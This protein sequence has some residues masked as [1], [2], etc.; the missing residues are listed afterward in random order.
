MS[1]SRVAFVPR[2]E[3]KVKWSECCSFV[4]RRGNGA[5]AISIGKNCDKFGIVVHE[6][7]HVV[8][9]WHEHTRPDRDKHVQII[10][11]NIVAGQEY[12]FN[13]LTEEEVNSLGLNYDYESIMHYARNT[14]SRSTALDTILPIRGK[15]V[16]IGQRVRLSSG[17]IA[18]TNMLYKCPA[19]GRTFQEPSSHFQSPGYETT[20]LSHQRCEWRISATQ[21]ER[22]SFEV[23]ALDIDPSCDTGYLEIRDGY[24]NKSPLLGRFCGNRVSKEKFVSSGHRMLVIYQ[25][26][27]TPIF[28]K[29]FQAKYEALCGG[30]LEQSEGTIQSPNYPDEYRANKECIWKI[31]VAPGSQVALTFQAFEVEYHDNCGYDFVEVRDGLDLH[32][33]FLA[34]LCGYK[35]PE[36][37]RSTS[38]HMLVRFFS[39][40]SV[41]KMG[42]SANFVTACGRTFQ[43]PS[44]HFQSPGYETTKLSHQRC[45]WRISATQGERISFEVTALDIDPSCDTGY[46]EIRDG[47]WNK[48]PLLGRFCG[49]RVSKEKFVSS[50]H[51]MLVIYQTIPTPIFYKG[52]QAK[53][54][55]ACGGV[56]K[57]ERGVITSPSFPDLYPSN[58]QCIWEIVAPP[59][60]RITLN[61]T[62]F[63]LEGTNQ[64][65]EYDS[66]DL[67]TRLSPDED[68]KKQGTYCGSRL[69]PVLTSEGSALRI[70]FVSDNSVQ[71][72]GFAALFFT[73]QDE[74]ASNNG[75]CQQICKNTVGS[76]QCS[77]H[78]GFVLHPNGHDCKEGS[79]VH[80]VSSTDGVV[81]SPNFPDNYPSRKECTWK[82]ETTP[83]HR[84]KLVFDSFEL[85]PHQECAYDHVA[86]YD[87]ESADS[88]LLGRFCGSKVPHPIISTAQ[89]MLMAFRS[90]PSV[91]RNGFRA[92]HST[93]CGGRLSATQKPSLL[94][95]HAKYGDQNYGS[96]ADC[97]WIVTAPNSGKVRIHFQSFD[98]EPEQDCAYDYVQVLD[99]FETSPSLGKFCG[100]KIPPDMTSSGFRMLIRFQSDDSIS[101]KGFALV[102][103]EVF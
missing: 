101:G 88:P 37:V 2:K 17:D 77:C 18:Q 49:N 100:N 64:E 10:T 92:T 21:G 12:N 75:G 36:E 52:F 95:S 86:L 85:E 60:Y 66:V 26:I 24:W 50:G 46:L 98:L 91:Q 30:L 65:C 14:F 1:N 27:P 9:F 19:C 90:D 63:D 78:N 6:L 87:G 39:D 31:S 72:S 42:F 43:E 69:P 84:I 89:T 79:C 99:G 29:G 68:W 59:H 34:R 94:Y 54:E 16:E 45:E 102:F 56:L 58:K 62:H 8:G 93:V 20:K 13:K 35:I 73:D 23:T 41:L 76:Y 83:G 7:G 47:Y 25:T 74:C 38:N 53:Y 11:R 4:G 67:R 70:E 97:N 103:S 40:S 22:I 5:Q 61:F 48:S 80:H 51:R 71:K 96:R 3:C 81:S 55:D 32:S 15:V 82:F 33:T 44:S 28:Y 57:G